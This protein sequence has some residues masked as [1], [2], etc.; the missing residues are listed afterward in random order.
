VTRW[1]AVF[2]ALWVLTGC[3]KEKV[4][5]LPQGAGVVV[6]GDSISAG[7]G[8]DP[9]FAWPVVL[10]S[11]SGWTTVNAGVSG[12]TTAQGLARLP[13]LLNEHKPAAV[14]IELGG[15]DMLRRQPDAAAVANL[16]AMISAVRAAGARPLLMATPRPSIAG[17]VFSSLSDADFYARLAKDAEVYLIPDVLSEVLSD[18]ANKLDQLHPNAEGQRLIAHAVVSRLRKD[19]WLR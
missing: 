6:L 16:R 2:A 18:T 10:G 19:G 11:L 3:S 7:H 12:D 8:L 5:P 13:A 1:L 14:I 17:A 4:A 15:N 9:A